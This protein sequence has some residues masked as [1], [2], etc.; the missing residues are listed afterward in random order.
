MNPRTTLPARLAAAT[1]LTASVVAATAVVVTTTGD[2]QAT[3]SAPATVTLQRPVVMRW[4]RV[5]GATSYRIWRDGVVIRT[6]TG[7]SATVLISC[8]GDTLHRLNVQA[9]NGSGKSAM[10]PPVYRSC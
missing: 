6:V 8:T 9:Q 1:I 3:P 5:P 7:L 2:T 10:K 4:T